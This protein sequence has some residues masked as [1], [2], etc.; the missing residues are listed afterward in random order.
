MAKTETVVQKAEAMKNPWQ[1]MRETMIHAKTRSEQ[2]T[3]YFNVNGHKFR[4]PKGVVTRVPKPIYDLIQNRND[5][6][7]EMY[8]SAKENFKGD[9]V[10][11]FKL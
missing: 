2:P 3:E 10:P 11:E 5:A 1:D 7:K 9:R 8:Q 4:V 6:E